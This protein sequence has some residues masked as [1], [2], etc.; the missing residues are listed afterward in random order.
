[1]KSEEK[2]IDGSLVKEVDHNVKLASKMNELEFQMIK[3]KY[4]TEY[5]K[6][7]KVQIIIAYFGNENCRWY[8]SME[9]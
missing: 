4:K 7:L 9:N 1:M 8:Q 5:T 3:K 2:E 6:N